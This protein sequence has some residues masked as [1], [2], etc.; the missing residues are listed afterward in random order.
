MGHR[1]SLLGGY[2]GIDVIDERNRHISGASN[3]S[4]APVCA[5]YFTPTIPK[6]SKLYL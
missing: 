2:T 6:G 4:V 3:R 5:R 1:R